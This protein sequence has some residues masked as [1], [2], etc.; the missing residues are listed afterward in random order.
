MD[1]Q[2]FVKTVLI[3]IDAA[4]D[5]AQALT[6]RAVRFSDKGNSRTVEFDIAVSVET[7]GGKEGKASLK[8]WQISETGGSMHSTSKNSSVSRVSFGVEVASKTKVEQSEWDQKHHAGVTHAH[9]PISNKKYN[10][11]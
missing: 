3:Q 8:I 5:E 11:E 9:K 2:E 1:L 10:Y 6:K 4:V 7:V